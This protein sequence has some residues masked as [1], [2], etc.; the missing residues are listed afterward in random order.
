[1][2]RVYIAERL[3]ALRLKAGLSQQSF[4]AALGIHWRSVQDWEIGRT[5][6]DSFKAEAVLKAAERLAARHRKS[7]GKK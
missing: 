7:K 1:M 3:K 2:A 4:A 5:R 6:V